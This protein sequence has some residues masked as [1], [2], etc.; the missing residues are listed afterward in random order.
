MIKFH[1]I[2]AIPV[3]G[4]YDTDGNLVDEEVGKGQQGIYTVEQFSDYL[5]ALRAEVDAR[6]T[7][8]AA[9]SPDPAE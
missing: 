9:T 6:N 3:V 2:L 1:K 7:A 4:H 8:E 5:A